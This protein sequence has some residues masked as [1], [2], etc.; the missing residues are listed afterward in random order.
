MHMCLASGNKS[1][2][3]NEA[4]SFKYAYFVLAVKLKPSSCAACILAQVVACH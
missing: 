4:L 1:I 2:L 3:R